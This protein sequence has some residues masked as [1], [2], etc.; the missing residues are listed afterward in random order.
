MNLRALLLV[1]VA[2][3]LS[4]CAQRPVVVVQQQCQPINQYDTRCEVQASQ[5]AKPTAAGAL[6]VSAPAHVTYILEGPEQTLQTLQLRI[7]PGLTGAV[8]N[9]VEL[10]KKPAVPFQYEVDVPV[11]TEPHIRWAGGTGVSCRVLVDGVDRTATP[12]NL[13][14]N[15]GIQLTEC[16]AT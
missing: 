2:F 16:Y 6:A 3:G 4:A 9:A 15:I 14:E 7:K 1:L 13:G 8:K 5:A 12:R 11:G 10:K